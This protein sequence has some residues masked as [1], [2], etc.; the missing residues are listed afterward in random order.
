[1]IRTDSK[2]ERGRGREGR[3]KGMSGVMN[4]NRSYLS[5]FLARK[6]AKRQKATTDGGYDSRGERLQFQKR[7]RERE[8]ERECKRILSI[9]LSLFPSLFWFVLNGT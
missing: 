8:S 9:F 5:V 7:E 4:L 3:E 1:L 6:R 2:R